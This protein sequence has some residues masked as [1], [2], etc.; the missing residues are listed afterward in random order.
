MD[1]FHHIGSFIFS[2]RRIILLQFFAA[3]GAASFGVGI[4]MAAAI[5]VGQRFPAE[6]EIDVASLAA[7]VAVEGGLPHDIHA[8]GSFKRVATMGASEG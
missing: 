4:E 3:L 5:A 6:A 1:V 2:K 8:I 7:A